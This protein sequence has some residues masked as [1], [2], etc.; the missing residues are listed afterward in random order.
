MTKCDFCTQSSPNGKCPY[1]STSYRQNYCDK[2][3]KQMVKALGQEPREN[4]KR[5]WNK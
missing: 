5:F 2:A 3:I 1:V 4:K